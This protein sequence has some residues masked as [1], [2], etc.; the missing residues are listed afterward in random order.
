MNRGSAV[1]EVDGRAT[2]RPMAMVVH[3]YYDE[4]PR[5]RREA[6]SLVAA[7]RPVDVFALRRPEDPAHDELDGVTIHRLDVQRHQGAGL[8]TYLLEYQAFLLRAGWALARAHRRRRYAVVQVHTL[9]DYLVGAALPLRLIGVPVILDLHEAMPEFFR[10]RFPGASNRI[11][12]G[13]LR[14]QERLSIAIATAAVTVNEAMRERLVDLGVRSDKITVIRNSPSLARFDPER[15]AR[16][17]FAVDGTV[18]LVYAGAL[19]PTYELDV[20]LESIARIRADR[21]D[22]ATVIDIYGRGDAAGSLADLATKLGIADQVRFHGRIP[23]EE[24][25][26]AVAGADIGLAPTRRDRFTDVSLST[27]VF[28]YAAMGKPVVASLLPMVER[29]FPPDTISTYAAGDPTSLAAAILG[30][31]D[32]PIGREAAVGRTLGIVAAA[33]WELEAIRY[34]ALVDR[35]A[36]PRDAR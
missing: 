15:H 26:A 18:R 5:V 12:H 34:I 28:E 30:L 8:R 3:A 9:P 33:A 27:K 31:V 14:L 13:L 7:G 6:E 10:S 2:R 19:T 25:P 22:L 29:T 21:P 16:R 20:V 4:D 23:I 17:A 1:D 24:V 32:D 11:A 35:L 36:G